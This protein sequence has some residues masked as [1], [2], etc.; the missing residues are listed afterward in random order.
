MGGQKGFCCKVIHLHGKVNGF[1]L[2]QSLRPLAGPQYTT[3][4]VKAIQKA[5]T[6]MLE[7]KSF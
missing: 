4:L 7:K 3:A 2:S 1:N 5:L 6:M